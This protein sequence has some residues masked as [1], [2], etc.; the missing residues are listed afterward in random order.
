MKRNLIFLGIGWFSLVAQGFGQRVAPSAE[1]RTDS[2]FQMVELLPATVAAIQT[3]E[4]APYPTHH[5]DAVALAKRDGAMDMPFLLRFTPSLVVTSDAGAGVGYTSMRIRG[6]DQTHINVTLNGVALNDAESHQVYWVDLPDLSSSVDGLT[7]QRGVGSASNGPGAFGATVAMETMQFGRK[8]GG[9]LVLGGGSFATLRSMVQWSTGEIG[10]GVFVEGRASRILSE[11]YLDRSGSDLSSMQVGIG[12]QWGQGQIAYTAILGH[13]RTQQ[14]W[15]GVPRVG[16]NGTP[17][18]IW[19]W[20]ANSYEYGYGSDSTRVLDLINRGRQHNYY[21]YDDQVDDYR[22]DHHQ[23]HLSQKLAGWDVGGTLHYTRGAGYFEQFRED[24]ELALYGAETLG[25]ADSTVTTGDVIRQRWLSNDFYGTVLQGSRQWERLGMQVGV[26]AFRY[27]GDHFGQPIWMEFGASNVSPQHRYYENVGSKSDRYAFAGVD[28][29]MASDAIRVRAEI[30]ARHVGYQVSGTDNDLRSLHVDTS[31]VFV[32]PKIGADWVINHRNRVFTSVA[33]ASREPVRTDYIDRATAAYPKP[34]HLTDVE[35]GWEYATDRWSVQAGAFYMQYRNQ[36]VLTG[37]LNDTGSPIRQNVDRSA[38][39][40]LEWT[41]EWR[42]I[43]GVKWY[44]TATLSDHRIASF[45]EVLIDYAEEVNPVVE[46]LHQGT[47]ISFSP[48][49]T[50]SSVASWEFFN[51]LSSDGSGPTASIEWSAR[52][53]GLQY[54]DN[55]QH[56][57]RALSAY[58]VQDA[59]VR[60]TYQRKAG[61]YIGCSLFVRNILNARYSANGWTYSYLYGGIESIS[62]EVYE[63][64]QAGRHGM[65]AL[66]FSF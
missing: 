53:V 34:E 56:A 57:A 6:S 51:R 31:M 65:F 26:G 48:R 4:R 45:T 10:S 5:L 63:Y 7:I 22:Q 9:R 19:A 32:N 61:G 41:Q 16:L 33:Q 37:A 43:N 1:G 14:A 50:A 20:A 62:T 35:A 2:L 29:A 23:V 30:Q 12:Q 39:V 17:E 44:A 28:R 55:T 42:P 52:Y 27:T 59:Q 36:L 11:G 3:P 64:P 24:D 13:E 8:A 58:S 54:L 38:R 66:E 21:R 60:W 15:Y 40:G 46:V 49:L 18:E 47:A 25:L